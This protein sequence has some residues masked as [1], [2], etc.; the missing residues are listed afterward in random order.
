MFSKC[1]LVWNML[2]A[3]LFQKDRNSGIW[4][5]NLGMLADT[6]QL[7]I[8]LK[9]YFLEF[10]DCCTCIKSTYFFEELSCLLFVYS[11]LRKCY[12]QHFCCKPDMLQLCRR[13]W[14]S[15][16]FSPTNLTLASERMQFH[17][18]IDYANLNLTHWTAHHSL[19]HSLTHGAEPFLRSCQ[20]CSYSRTS[21]PFME[22]EGSLPRSQEPSTS[23]YP[24]S[25]RSNP[26]HPIL[27]L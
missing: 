20:L 24:E 17:N 27:S 13:L 7:H 9:N 8:S 6:I 22:P 3:T 10:K 19:T 16:L 4:N 11:A 14:R 5:L 23:P 12:S 18:D 1:W 26:Y 2:F 21:Q 15:R 25:D